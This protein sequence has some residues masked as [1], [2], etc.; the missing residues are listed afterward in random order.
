MNDWQT[1]V[2]LGVVIVATVFL[3]RRATHGKNKGCGHDCGCGKK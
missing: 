2:A 1:W 3:V